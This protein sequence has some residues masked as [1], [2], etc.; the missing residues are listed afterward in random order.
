MNVKT[1]ILAI[2]MAFMGVARADLLLWQTSSTGS[3]TVDNQST[4]YAY[5]QLKY[6]TDQGTGT[7]VADNYLVGT[8]VSVGDLVTAGDSVYADVTSI[9]SGGSAQMSDYYF[10]IELINSAGNVVANSGWSDYQTWSQYVVGGT[11]DESFRSKNFA[12]SQTTWSAGPVPEPTSG[13]MLL[14]GAAMLGLRRK[15]VA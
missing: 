9:V 14:I 2:C 15:K 6:S 13:L 12:Q 4:E 1:T 8:G 5:A 11:F 7:V 3:V 10:T